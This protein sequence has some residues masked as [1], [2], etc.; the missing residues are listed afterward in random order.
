MAPQISYRVS[1]SAGL[2]FILAGTASAFCPPPPAVLKP[3]P[4]EIYGCPVYSS[5]AP[6]K[7]WFSDFVVPFDNNL[8][9][10]Y[11]DVQIDNTGKVTAGGLDVN[12]QPPMR[13]R[14][15]QATQIAGIAVQNWMMTQLGNAQGLDYALTGIT[16]TPTGTI[17]GTSPD[18]PVITGGAVFQSPDGPVNIVTGRIRQGY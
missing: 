14:E 8:Y 11:V 1:L 13:G 16:F 9:G 12:G 3:Q 18:G 15:L 10:F 6:G 5:A 17:T 7:F 4:G 2:S